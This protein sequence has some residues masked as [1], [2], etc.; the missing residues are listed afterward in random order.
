MES[1]AF[2]TASADQ[3][4]VIH[5]ATYANELARGELADE[6]VGVEKLSD[7]ETS[8]ANERTYTCIAVAGMAVVAYLMLI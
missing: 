4:E 2:S 7:Q 6:E 1:G 3:E 8:T 5:V